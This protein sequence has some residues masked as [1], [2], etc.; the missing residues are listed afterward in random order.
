M[1]TSLALALALA[2]P[3]TCDLLRLCRRYVDL[4]PP[5]FKIFFSPVC[6]PASTCTP[7]WTPALETRNTL[8]LSLDA[9]NT[10]LLSAPLLCCFFD[11]PP[12]GLLSRPA[13]FRA[14]SRAPSRG[15]RLTG[16][17]VAEPASTSPPRPPPI[18]FHPPLG[19]SNAPAVRISPSPVNLHRAFQKMAYVR[20]H[21]MK[22]R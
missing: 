5:G 7:L 11:L 6:F 18:P 2:P 13:P 17:S 4:A 22:G 14:P 8:L 1:N 19:V 15:G 16:M 3:T 20:T 9:R 12:P 21:T 10:L